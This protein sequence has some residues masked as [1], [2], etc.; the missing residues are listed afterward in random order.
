MVSVGI[1]SKKRIF[2]ETAPLNARPGRKS[3]FTDTDLEHI[4]LAMCDRVINKPPSATPQPHHMKRAVRD[5]FVA[6]AQNFAP[7]AK[8]PTSKTFHKRWEALKK[9]FL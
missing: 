2:L 1:T 5:A 4:A 8:I 7:G 6:E 9:E 3:I